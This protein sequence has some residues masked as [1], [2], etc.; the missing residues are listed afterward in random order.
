MPQR[1][2]VRVAILHSPPV[3]RE[4]M[5]RRARDCRGGRKASVITGAGGEQ[6]DIMGEIQYGVPPGL[7]D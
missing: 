1:P 5:R 4:T 7:Q 3:E 2:S 6:S